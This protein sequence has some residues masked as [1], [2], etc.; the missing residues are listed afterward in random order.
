MCIRDSVDSDHPT[1]LKQL[2]ENGVPGHLITE[3]SQ[4]LNRCELAKFAGRYGNME[5]E[6]NIALK[7]IEEV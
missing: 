7:L 5:E 3:Y 6:Y 4:I 1:I 2:A